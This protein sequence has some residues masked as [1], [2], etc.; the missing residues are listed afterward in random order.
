M[1]TYRRQS[2]VRVGPAQPARSL[3]DFRIVFVL[4]VI[5]LIDRVTLSIAMPTIAKEFC[6]TASRAYP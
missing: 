2:E 1:I 5:K 3:A 4:V 6:L